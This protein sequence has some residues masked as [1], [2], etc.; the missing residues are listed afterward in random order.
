MHIYV[1]RYTCLRNVRIFHPRYTVLAYLGPPPSIG[2]N[3]SLYNALAINYGPVPSAD[4]MN[5]DCH[6][7]NHFTELGVTAAF[8]IC[9]SR[10]LVVL[11]VVVVVVVE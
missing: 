5:V 2:P 9:S 11:V 6:V 7:Y 10:N 1:P 8:V 4:L 3:G